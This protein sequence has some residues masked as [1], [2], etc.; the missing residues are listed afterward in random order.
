MRRTAPLRAASNGIRWLATGLLV[1]SLG[2]PVSAQDNSDR[3]NGIVRDGDGQ[4]VADVEV[5]MQSQSV[6]TADDGTFELPFPRGMLF[7]QT[8]TAKNAAGDQQAY[9]FYMWMRTGNETPPD[10]VELTLGTPAKVTVQVQNGDRQPL[11]GVRVVAICDYSHKLEGE[12]DANG[13]AELSIPPGARLRTVFAR[14][15]NVG[16]DYATLINEQAFYN[17]QLN[18][19]APAPPTEPV[20]LVLDGA[21]T[22]T[23][24]LVD[25]D[26]RPIAETQIWPWLFNKNSD[27]QFNAGGAMDEFVLTTD[28]Q[29]EATMDWWPDWE[30]SDKFVFWPMLRNGNQ[31]QHPVDLSSSPASVTI[32]IERGVTISGTVRKPDK[33]PAANVSVSVRGVVSD[34]NQYGDGTRTGADGRYSME[35]RPDSICMVV[36]DDQDWAAPI[37]TGIIVEPKKPVENVDIDL[38]P[39]TKVTGRVT[40]AGKPVANQQIALTQSGMDGTTKPK[41]PQRI[42]SGGPYTV[43]VH[44]YRQATTDADGRY[45]FRLGPGRYLM[46]AGQNIAQQQFEIKQE[47]TREF[48]FAVARPDKGPLT[49]S[50]LG[51]EPPAPLARAMVEI[52][53]QNNWWS[54][55]VI[56]TDAQGQVTVERNLAQTFIHARSADGLLAATKVIGADDM[57]TQITVAPCGTATGRLVDETGQPLANQDFMVGIRPDT[58]V[59][60]YGGVSFGG[61]SSKTDGDGRFTLPNLIVSQAYS[62]DVPQRDDRPNMQAREP[63]SLK[64]SGESDVGDVVM[65]SAAPPAS[66]AKVAAAPGAPLTPAV[67]SFSWARLLL[68]GNLIGIPLLV[69]GVIAARRLTR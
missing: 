69:I 16:F 66:S 37:R 12:T 53:A 39:A 4:P 8:I 48:D 50:V 14:Q 58:G 38:R 15:P 10:L 63:F 40:V 20:Q 56:Q 31:E 46:R 60:I 30:K 34:G 45:E 18:L 19:P 55:T 42:G 3:V 9:R 29:G 7:G 49:V 62:M 52:R 33:S 65:K 59:T 13:R 11:S 28:S 27:Q 41:L 22:L 17:D 5:T 1:L 64:T 51:G 36:I 2:W 24:K 43:T 57:T 35:V 67:T 32:K 21:R 44:Y 25:S 68:F 61:G 54:P 47:T 23:V 6:K 26:D